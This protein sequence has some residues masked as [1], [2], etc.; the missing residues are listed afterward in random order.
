LYAIVRNTA[1]SERRRRA[2][3]PV[4]VEVTDGVV[5]LIPGQRWVGPESAALG[6]DAIRHALAALDEPFR[7]AFELIEVWGYG[8][9]D[10]AEVIGAPAATLRTR[11]WRARREI[12]ARCPEVA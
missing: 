7:T 5:P 1:L 10:A 9:A 4:P 6:R 3:R 11:V 2:R 8:Y 12:R